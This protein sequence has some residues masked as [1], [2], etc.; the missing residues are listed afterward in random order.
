[1]LACALGLPL[2]LQAEWNFA[3]GWSSANV[4]RGIDLSD[5][6]G[7]WLVGAHYRDDRGWFAGASANQL[8][9]AGESGAQVLGYVG[10]FVPLDGRLRIG[11]LYTHYDQLAG[12]DPA[13]RYDEAMVSLRYRE[14][15]SLN[16]ALA[17]NLEY[18]S[19]RF[20]GYN[21]DVALYQPLSGP[22]S[23]RAGLGDFYADGAGYAYRYLYGNAGLGY[24][25][26]PWNLQLD[27]VFTDERGEESFGALAVNRWVGSV[28]FHF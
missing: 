16:L 9:L 18:G 1:M 4:L 23:L 11:A 27:Y 8:D 19:S 26:G 2:P 21:T 12:P 22:W 5:G 10:G 7:A 13:Y 28:V 24:S 15:L 25:R 6:H 20:R 3:G 17:P 14:R